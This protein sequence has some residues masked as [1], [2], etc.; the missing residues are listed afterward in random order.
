MKTLFIVSALL[1]EGCGGAAA[2][3]RRTPDVPTTITTTTS[4]P[5]TASPPLFTGSFD[6]V[7]MTDPKTSKSVVV[8]DFVKQLKAHDGRMTFAFAPDTFT[9][10]FWQMGELD[11]LAQTDKGNERFATFCSATATVA[12]HWEA[13]TIVLASTVKAQGRAA[14]V[15]VATSGNASSSDRQQATSSNE[16]TASFSATRITFEI[17]EKDDAGPTKLRGTA[18]GVIIDLA[19]GKANKELHPDKLLE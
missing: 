16:C 8:A 3:A 6:V 2:T 1:L 4:K 17:V 12:A 10:G 5:E 15:R 18:E 7:A 11:K 13:S 14:T 9:I 19:R